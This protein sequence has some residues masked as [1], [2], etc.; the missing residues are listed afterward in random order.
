MVY[1]HGNV[2]CKTSIRGARATP[3]RAECSSRIAMTV[4]VLNG[5]QEDQYDFVM[6][7][8]LVFQCFMSVS[9]FNNFAK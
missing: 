3:P 7:L 8:V 4:N 9:I 1:I 5:L 2:Q 6:L